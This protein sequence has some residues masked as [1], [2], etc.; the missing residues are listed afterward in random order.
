MEI[1]Q[2]A[3]DTLMEGFFGGKIKKVSAEGRA[4]MTMDIE[5]LHSG[6]DAIHSCRPIRGKAYV[7]AVIKV[8]YVPEDEVLQWMT[9]N[10][11]QYAH[12]H[13]AGLAVQ[14]MS[15]LISTKKLKDAL[16]HIDLLYSAVE[17]STASGGGAGA[18]DDS[19]GSG[20]IFSGH[21]SSS[22]VSASEPSAAAE[23][24]PPSQSS[25][26]SSSFSSMF[27]KLRQS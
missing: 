2:A 12:N 5:A 15:S 1:C 4:T 9:E 7:D 25:G 14:Q 6:L 18:A 13:L 26:M 17:G 8:T 23:S 3:F 21:S 16:T 10:W 24:A 20:G 19:H 27:S 22:S 11:S